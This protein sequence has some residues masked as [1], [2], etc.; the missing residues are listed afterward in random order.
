[1]TEIRYSEDHEYARLEGDIAIIG[2][3]DHA[4]QQ[5]GD[6][7]FVELPEIGTVF[8]VGA[9]GAVVESVKA[10][11]EIFIPLAGE[12]VEVN[13]DLADEPGLVNEDAEGD[14]WFMKIKVS[15]P[16]QMEKL[17]TAEAYKVYLK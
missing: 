3:S 8:S 10:A 4:Q 9:V 13:K 12:V 17:M 11:S 7:V 6:V 2:I 14:G 15:D 16:S 1:M 5:L